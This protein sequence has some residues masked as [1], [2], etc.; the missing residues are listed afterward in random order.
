MG[1]AFFLEA[2]VGNDIAD[3][4]AKKS[5]KKNNLFMNEVD[6]ID[7]ILPYF[8]VFLDNPVEVDI[9][10][11]ILRILATHD[12]TEWSL[13]KNNQELYHMQFTKIDWKIT[14]LIFYY[15]KRFHCISMR[16]N[17]LWTFIAKLFHKL[18][19]LGSVLKLRKLELYEELQCIMGCD[20]Q[21]NWNHLFECS[22][23]N[24]VW[25]KIFKMTLDD[26][27]I[28]FLKHD[29]ISLQGENFIRNVLQKNLGI[30]FPLST[31]NLDIANNMI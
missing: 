23:Y 19:P 2:S 7:N 21:K 20:K 6:F 25:K 29:K 5:Q 18:L 4:L 27:I 15:Y 9:R 10:Q 11:F 14:W 26:S 16:I 24:S 28:I 3:E 22:A 13:L 30:Q 31:A 12:A 17:Q 1:V 8:L